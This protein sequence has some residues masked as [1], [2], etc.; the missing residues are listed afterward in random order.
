M[1]DDAGVMA[2]F[3]ANT[4]FPYLAKGAALELPDCSPSKWDVQSCHTRIGY[5]ERN[6]LTCVTI[7][8]VDSPAFDESPSPKVVRCT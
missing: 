5:D 6:N 1:R 7:V 4:P 8:V 3:T 2:Q